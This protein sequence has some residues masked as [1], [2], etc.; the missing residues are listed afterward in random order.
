MAIKSSST[1]KLTNMTETDNT[2]ILAGRVIG[3]IPP[4]SGQMQAM[5]R[6]S[7]T[8][9]KGTDDDDKGFW[10]TQIN[11]IG[12][13]LESLIAEADRDLV[14]ELYLT[15]KVDHADLMAAIMGKINANATASED[16]AIEKA[17]ANVAR[18]RR[19]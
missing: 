3:F 17:K 10:T 19:K 15:G 6:I 1:A 13:L 5:I 9:D 2:I 4:T 18:V 16:K 14:D 11:R 8:I 7:R 12:I